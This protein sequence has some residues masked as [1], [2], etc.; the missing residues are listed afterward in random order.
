MIG[1]VGYCLKSGG[2]VEDFD[3]ENRSAGRSYAKTTKRFGDLE[4]MLGTVKDP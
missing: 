2:S 3:G 4:V 1:G